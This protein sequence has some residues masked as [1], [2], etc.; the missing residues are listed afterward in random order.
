MKNNFVICIRNTLS[1]AFLSS[2]LTRSRVFTRKKCPA[3]WC[4]FHDDRTINV[5]SR[6]H[7]NKNAPLPGGHVFQP[8]GTIFKTIQDIN[9]TNLLTKFNEDRTLWPVEKNALP[10]DGHVFSINWTNLLTKVH[11]DWTAN[12]ATRVLTR[13]MLMPHDARQTKGDHKSS[14]KLKATYIIGTNFLP[15][16]HEDLLPK[17]NAP[18]TDI[19]G[20]NLLTNVNKEKCP[21]PGGHVFQSNRTIFELVQ[22]IIGINLL[23][24]FHEDQ[25][26]NVAPRVLPVTRK[27]DLPPC[28]HVFQATG[29][30]F[31]LVQDIIGIN[32]LTKFHD[33]RTIKVV[34]LV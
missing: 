32:L 31:E 4:P 5:A 13:Q 16:F 12:V 21:A 10:P 8:T 25:T 19:I 27:N 33:Y 30:I 6:D 9:A 24:K 3:T 23:T 7:I 17:K 34:S 1:S 14:L 26:I 18:P 29:T 2:D 11:K 22:D 28:G 20:T 15:K